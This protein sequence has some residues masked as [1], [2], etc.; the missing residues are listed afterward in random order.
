M[1]SQPRDSSKV[2]IA[3]RWL[4]VRGIYNSSE[5]EL[6]ILDP[7]NSAVKC[8]CVMF[9]YVCSSVCVLMYC[10]LKCVCGWMY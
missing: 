4:L 7:P 2:G 1:F 6:A 9:R 8:V 10:A 5:T 3:L